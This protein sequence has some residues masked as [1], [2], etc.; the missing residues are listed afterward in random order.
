MLVCSSP[1]MKPRK[2]NITKPA[3]MDVAQLAIDTTNASLE[4]IKVITDQKM[5]HIFYRLK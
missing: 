2:E 4:D 3:K 1:A 5:G